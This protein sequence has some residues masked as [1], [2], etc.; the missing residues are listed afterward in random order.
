MNITAAITA[1][2]ITT[3]LVLIP[4]TSPRA[5][6]SS[7]FW[8]SRSSPAISRG[9]PSA[10]I[11]TGLGHGLLFAGLARICSPYTSWARDSAW[12]D[13]VGDTWIVGVLGGHEDSELP[14]TP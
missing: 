11:R 12:E 1:S 9:M 8:A 7:P 4:R 5:M 13:G 10:Y 14:R 6:L 3:R 2:K